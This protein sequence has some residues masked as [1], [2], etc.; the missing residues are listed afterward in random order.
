MAQSADALAITSFIAR[1]VPE[2]FRGTS[3]DPMK[4]VENAKKHVA[5]LSK[6]Q[7]QK[8]SQQKTR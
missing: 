5:E 1:H 7:A 2:K 6:Q 8:K 3:P 4:I